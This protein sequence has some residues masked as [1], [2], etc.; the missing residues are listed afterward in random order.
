VYTLTDSIVQIYFFD[1]IMIIV[2]SW[3]SHLFH[4]S[5]YL[6]LFHC[7]LIFSLYTC[8]VASETLGLHAQI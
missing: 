8:S 1:H 6:M 3:I 7:F 4:V 5:L 2:I